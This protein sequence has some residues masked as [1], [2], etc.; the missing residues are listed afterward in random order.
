MDAFALCAF[1]RP[2]VQK[3]SLKDEDKKDQKW[4]V[5]VTSCHCRHL[6][7]TGGTNYIAL[8]FLNTC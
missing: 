5:R 2:L 8:L 1:Y 3:P 4:L 6:S 7:L